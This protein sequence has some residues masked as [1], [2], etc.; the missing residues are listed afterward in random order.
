MGH[1]GS[2]VPGLRVRG[3]S[4]VGIIALV[5]GLILTLGGCPTVDLGE[6]PEDVGLCNPSGGLDYF[7]TQIWPMYVR[8][9]NTTNGCTKSGASCHAAGEGNAL[10]F[11]ID[12][13]P[14]F[15]ANFRAAR[16]YLNCGTPEMSLLLTK[17]LANIEA[18]GGGD[19]FPSK[20]DAAVQAFLG[21]F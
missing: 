14:D 16:V 7:T 10:G 5:L 18:H 9:A 3:A 8:P 15:A 6:P 21:W 2:S 1:R 20:D 13:A 17:P 11:R 19:I 4:A 12:P